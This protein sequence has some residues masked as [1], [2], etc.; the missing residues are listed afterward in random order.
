MQ[1]ECDPQPANT[2]EP[3]HP[4]Q[5]IT[6]EAQYYEY[7]T[8]TAGPR[9]RIDYS[10]SADMAVDAE[11]V[12]ALEYHGGT[13]PT[14]LTEEEELQLALKQIQEM[15]MQQEKSAAGSLE[16]ML[17]QGDSVY[18]LY[19]VMVHN[20]GAYGG[21]Y[22]AY[23]RDQE[24]WFNFNDS[25]VSP[26]SDSD[27]QKTFG[28]DSANTAYMLLYRKHGS[29]AE[30]CSPPDYFKAVLDK[31]RQNA[32]DECKKDLQKLLGIKFKIYFQG[33]LEVIEFGRD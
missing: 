31:D 12:L 22:F 25:S 6:D 24:Q 29:P 23:I 33:E 15:E 30:I 16:E 32:L 27:L 13:A 19:A 20:G 8:S 5:G 7:L 21:H 10:R 4:R 2:P 3:S 17:K 26:L 9:K 18:K 14:G 1:A 28:G 11:P